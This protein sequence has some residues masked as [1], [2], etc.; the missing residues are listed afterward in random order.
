MTKAAKA[1]SVVGEK[2]VKRMILVIACLALSVPMAAGAE[3]RPIQRL[4]WLIGEWEFADRQ[5][6][7]EYRETGSRSCDWALNGEYIE[8]ISIGTSHT[9]KQR[10]YRWFFN[11]NRLEERFEAIS[12]FEGFPRKILQS[13]NLSDDNHRL[14]MVYGGWE[15][16]GINFET[17]AIVTYNGHDAYVWES[18]APHDGPETGEHQVRFRDTVTRKP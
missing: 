3:E 2:I 15:H 5:I 11:Y 1:R 9:G 18:H 4:S 6:G 12:I 16:D 17:H 13:I 7:G 8:C 10:S 14:E